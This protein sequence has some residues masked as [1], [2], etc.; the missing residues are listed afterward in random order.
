MRRILAV[1]GAVL[2]VALAGCVG[3]EPGGRYKPAPTATPVFASDE[4]ALA[5]A[6]VAYGAYIELADQI[7]VEGGKNPERLS[8]VATGAFL[9]ASVEEFRQVKLEGLVSTGGTLF[10]DMILQSYD[11]LS[12]NERLVVVYVCEDVSAV[13]VRNASGASA[14]SPDRPDTT[15][16]QAA[17]DLSPAGTLLVSSR[18]AWSNDPC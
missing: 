12:G 4:E 14:V 17:F 1:A 16:F 15:T 5:A 9:K 2:L 3:P 11:P 6:E 10:R 8:T 13:D 7:F 18:E